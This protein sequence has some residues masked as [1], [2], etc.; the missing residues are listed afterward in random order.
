MRRLVVTS[1]FLKSTSRK[2][3]SREVTINALSR[4]SFLPSFITTM[5]GIGKRIH[6]SSMKGMGKEPSWL[7][8]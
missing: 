5:E 1:D 3:E 6:V 4:R 8:D 2:A 7:S